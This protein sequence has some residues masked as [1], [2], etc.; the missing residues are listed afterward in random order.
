[1]RFACEKHYFMLMRNIK[2]ACF[3]ALNSSINDAFKVSNDTEIQGWHAG[4]QVINII[5]QL[6]TIYGQST[7]AILETSNT[8]FHSP[9]LAANAPEVLFRHIKEY[10][11]MALLSR[12]PY[13]DQQLVTNTILLL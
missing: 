9:Y 8:V 2:Q 5:D 13:T 6:S 1:M 4:M 3:T 10:A 7:P 11:K 12:N